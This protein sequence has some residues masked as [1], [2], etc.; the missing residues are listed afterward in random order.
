M[1]AGKIASLAE[2][3]G[4][5]FISPDA[6]GADLF[7]HC[8]VVDT[9]FRALRSGQQVHYEI[10]A[11]AAQPRAKRVV[12]GGPPPPSA[13]QRPG[14]R[15][16][17]GSASPRRRTPTGRAASPPQRVAHGFITKLPRKKLIG[18]ISADQGGAEFCFEPSD[19]LGDKRFQ[20]LVVG[21]FVSFVPGENRDVRQE[22]RATAVRVIPKPQP[23]KQ[24]GL[25]KHPRARRKKPTWR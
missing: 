7:F 16:S 8:S 13:S 19:V 25:P 20:D 1:L 18:F 15:A 4:F 24:N 6:G 23:P 9:E 17:A 11:T 21:D 22:P 10:D 3:K 2:N 5:G 12:A 14:N